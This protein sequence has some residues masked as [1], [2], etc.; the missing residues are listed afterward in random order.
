MKKFLTLFLLLIY[1][2]CFNR[3]LACDC[4][5]EGVYKEFP[6]NE[7]TGYFA[8]EFDKVAPKPGVNWHEDAYLWLDSARD[9]GW[10][11]KG[12]PEEAI[13]G[14]LLVGVDKPSHVLIGI[15]REVKEGKIIY[16]TL[17]DNNHVIKVESDAARLAQTLHVLGYIWPKRVIV[18]E[19][20]MEQAFSDKFKNALFVDV[21]PVNKFKKGHIP[22][23][24]S[25]PLQE[26]KKRMHEIPPERKVL[27]ICSTGKGSAEA[28]VL[29]QNYGYYNTYSVVGGMKKWPGRERLKQEL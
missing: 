12:T 15:V 18:Q 9:K 27:L 10:V 21:R 26:L 1:I 17:D 5:S 13:P 25:I 11:V 28:N 23:A 2:L 14:A 16:E 7:A 19:V 4:D 20:P 6:M 8:N 24:V 22:G 29:L 3:V